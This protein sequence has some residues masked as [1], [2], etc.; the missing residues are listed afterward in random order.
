MPIAQYSIFGW[1]ILGPVSSLEPR[2]YSTHHATIQSD[3][4]TLQELLTK[5]W[6]QEESPPDNNAS[7]L[8]PEKQECED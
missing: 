2:A 1:L 7:Q 5:F 6:V 3:N 8:T 4:N